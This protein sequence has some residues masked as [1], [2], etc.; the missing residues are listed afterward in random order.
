MGHG[1]NGRLRSWA[2]KK[3]IMVNWFR[4]A[5]PPEFGKEKI[6]TDQELKEIARNLALLSVQGVREFYER[7]YR[8]CR[9]SGRDFPPARAVQELV[10]AWKQLRKWRARG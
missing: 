9:I 6:W 5:R 8:E 7:A 1:A 3:R 10:Q 2:N 4:M